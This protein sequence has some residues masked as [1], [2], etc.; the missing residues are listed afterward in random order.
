MTLIKLIEWKL[1][2]LFFR[3]VYLSTQFPRSEDILISAWA[4]M[5]IY[6]G[7]I[8]H[9]DLLSIAR[10]SSVYINDESKVVR[11]NNF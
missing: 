2:E 1:V 10:I 5:A 9:P 4:T 6:F 11:A 7:D 3:W 8:L